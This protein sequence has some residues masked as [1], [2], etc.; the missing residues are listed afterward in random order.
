MVRILLEEGNADPNP[1]DQCR[2]TPL[3]HAV[4]RANSNI[5]SYL[6][7]HNADINLED[8]RKQTPQDLANRHKSRRF[9]AEILRSQLVDGPDKSV[10]HSYLGNGSLPDTRWGR[11]ACRDIEIQVTEVFAYDNTDQHWTVPISVEELIYGNAPL[12]ESL[13]QVRPRRVERKTP[14]CVWI[15]VL[16][17]NIMQYQTF[18]LSNE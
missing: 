7:E 4:R 12:A 14:I 8:D 3:H 6:L 10:H 18:R 2:N 15:H 11:L 16:E 17:N 13:R 5:V 9:V 1:Q